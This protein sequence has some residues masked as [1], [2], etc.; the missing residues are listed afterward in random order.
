MEVLSKKDARKIIFHSQQFDISKF[1]GKAKEITLKKI[2]HL[3]YVQIDTISVIERAHNHT[4]WNRNSSFK[5]SHIDSLIKE[6]E[7][8]EYWSHALS[9]LPMKDYRYSYYL[10]E[11]FRDKYENRNIRIQKDILT[12]IKNEGPLMAKD[13]DTPNTKRES[14]GR[15]P[16]KRE[17]SLLFLDGT[18]MIDSRVNF[19]KVYNLKEKIIPNHLDITRPS[20]DEYA[21]F[22][23]NR[24]LKS[25]GIGK[26]DE[27]IYLIPNLKS[28]IES[29]LKNMVENNEIEEVFV[30]G[31]L[32][33][34]L[35]SSYDLLNKPYPRELIKILSPFDNMIIQRKRLKKL[36]DFEYTLECY[37][38]K[39]KRKYGYFAL[40]IYYKDK[41]VARMDCAVDRK[42]K[43]LSVK[44]LIFE[45]KFNNID[46]FEFSFRKEFNKFLALNDC[47][48]YNFK[49]ISQNFNN[50]D[51]NI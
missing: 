6:R 28:L 37:V 32:Y 24:Y 42:T 35:K 48:S 17:L 9:F 51:L 15:T 22:L 8:F 13:F 16:Y 30:E 25:N 18:L 11:Y 23:I 20:D 40:P 14:W 1:K 38:P 45:P 26:L 2:E 21:H 29:E 19:H 7:I 33:Y 3:G 50:I 34:I 4:I 47:K 39:E 36:Y 10:Q 5:K 44:Q 12:R 31:S 43:H 41:F 49:K 46:G 27:F